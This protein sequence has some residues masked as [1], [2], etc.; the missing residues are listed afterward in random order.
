MSCDELLVKARL[1]LRGQVPSGCHRRTKAWLLVIVAVQADEQRGVHAFELDHAPSPTRFWDRRQIRAAY[2]NS[3]SV[4]PRA[5]GVREGSPEVLLF[6]LVVLCGP[7]GAS[8]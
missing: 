8:K 7:E 4:P 5:R 3:R 1:L 2:A 6:E